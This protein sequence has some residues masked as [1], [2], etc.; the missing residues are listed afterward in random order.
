MDFTEFGVA[1]IF[2][3]VIIKEVLTLWSKKKN[4]KN[5]IVNQRCIM[6]SEEFKSFKGE[7]RSVKEKVSHLDD[8]HNRYDEDGIPLWYIP[9]GWAD[10]QQKMVE[11]L[12][13]IDNSQ[14]AMV[15][16][17]ERIENKV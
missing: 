11:A 12:T 13:S 17:L 9:R 7:M 14:K 4:G 10:V 8:I 2:A 6:A 15:K 1:G 16:S 5:G 3:Y